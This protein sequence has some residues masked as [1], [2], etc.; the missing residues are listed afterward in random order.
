MGLTKTELL[1][2]HLEELGSEYDN[3][4]EVAEKEIYI[5]RG[6]AAALKGAEKKVLTL[7]GH[8]AR[9]V[10]EQKITIEAGDYAQQWIKKAAGVLDNLRAVSEVQAQRSEGKVEALRQVV[11]STKK[12]HDYHAARL[13]GAEDED[14]N[15][16]GDGHPGPYEPYERR[17]Q[18]AAESD[19]EESPAETDEKDD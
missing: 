2:A 18:D 14:D 4:L 11:L 17:E 5:H 8:I 19:E 16:D 1:M 7:L 10:K 15:A 12:K 6:G 3:K 9:D 13:G